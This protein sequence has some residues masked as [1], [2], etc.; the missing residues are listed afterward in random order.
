MWRVWECK[1][2]SNQI[3]KEEKPSMCLE[4]V[5]Q[6]SYVKNQ[7]SYVKNIE[8]VLNTF[9]LDLKML[10]KKTLWRICDKIPSE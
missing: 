1:Y 10:K 6:T 2:E 9:F 4:S 7:T 3:V 5:N 8:A